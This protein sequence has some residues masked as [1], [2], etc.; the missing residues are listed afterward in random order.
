[1]FILASQ[2]PRRRLILEQM[3][4]SFRVE[5]SQVDEA[6]IQSQLA[7]DQAGQPA[8]PGL[9]VEALAGA[10]A[11]EVANRHPQD[12]VLGADT[13][14]VW[15]GHIL[16]KPHRPEEAVSMLR[17]LSGHAHE[18][19][20]GVALIGPGHEAVFHDVAKVQ[21]NEL[22]DY[23]EAAIQAYVASGQAQDKAGAYG[24]QDAGANLIS[25]IQGDF[26]T[27]MGLPLARTRK[28]LYQLVLVFML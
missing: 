8:G 3:G 19:Y 16:G 12:L 10:K 17:Q 20:T 13:V 11:R 7:A 22:D 26:Y 18:V 24:I 21:F 27:V 1:M 23:Q 4:L 28:L 15:A 25:G 9:L 5:S 14:V 2:S 6:A